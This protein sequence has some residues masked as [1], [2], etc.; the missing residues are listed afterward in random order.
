MFKK[1]II[2]SIIILA[3]FV[4]YLQAHTDVFWTI[5]LNKESQ[6]C[7]EESNQVCWVN[8]VLSVFHKRGLEYSLNFVSSAYQR[9]PSFSKVCHDV[10]H[11][12][13]KETY[14]L[15][16]E[17][18]EF[19][20]SS[21]ASFCSY[22]FYHGFMESMVSSEEDLKKARQFCLYVDSQISKITPDATL[23][24][25][26][27]IGHGWVNIH[28]DKSLWGNDLGIIKKGLILCERVS[29]NDSELSRCA[30]GVFNGVSV[31]YSTE[32]SG[33]KI[34]KDDPLWICKAQ[35]NKYQ[36]PCFISMN[37]VL[38]AL[39]DGDLKV[40]SKYLEDIPDDIV[41]SHAMINL[42]IPFGLRRYDDKD[43]RDSVGICRSLQERLVVP[44]LQG[45]AFAFLEHGEPGKEYV[46]SLDFCKENDLTETE[47]NKCL[48]YI[49]AYLA[50]WY[51]QDKAVEICNN[52]GGYQQY[53]HEQLKIGLEGLNQ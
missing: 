11:L 35:E 26:H 9:D 4:F 48:G 43:H 36:D 14:K 20:I 32:E 45:Y 52:E 50:Q 18:K 24:C 8:L 47:E 30:T 1:I 38:M 33:L 29:E 13:G 25:F 44:C 12:L 7:T 37:T 21:N 2:L 19:Q 51:A 15:F 42:A 49:Y 6:K 27:G 53:C 41:A 31:F 39:N 34:K 16:D 10:G 22:G 23:Q 28:E 40:A 46:R 17:G 5:Q 3:L